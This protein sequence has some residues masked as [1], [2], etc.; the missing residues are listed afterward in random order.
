[1]LYDPKWE[2]TTKAD[3][4]TLQSLI[5]YLEAHPSDKPY[6]YT[7]AGRCLLHGYFAAHGLPIFSVGPGYY[8]LTD[9]RAIKLPENF[10]AI[11]LGNGDDGDWTFGAALERAR[12][13]T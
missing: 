11:S 12:A 2:K 3:P 5:A 1:M 13:A 8:R 4:L 9:Y 7:A 10:E 6:C